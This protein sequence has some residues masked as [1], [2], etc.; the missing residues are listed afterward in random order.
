MKRKYEGLIVFNT[1]GKDDAVD[2][3]VS[4]LGREMELDG[5]KLEQIDKIGKRRFPYGSKGEAEGYY[6]C[7]HLEA[8][9]GTLDKVR[10]K[11]RLN[12]D[13]HQQYFQKVGA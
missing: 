1:R 13:V 3:M 2:T 10:A 4:K 5:A 9:A 8:E 11:L 7:Y 12:E 6:V